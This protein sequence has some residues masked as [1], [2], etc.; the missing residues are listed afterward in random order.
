M[1][2]KNQALFGRTGDSRYKNLAG[3]SLKSSIGSGFCCR[4]LSGLG[5]GGKAGF[6]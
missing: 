2:V 1:T 4:L 5:F 6:F 3:L